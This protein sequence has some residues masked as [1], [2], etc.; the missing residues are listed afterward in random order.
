MSMLGGAGQP[1]GGAP[2]AQMPQQQQQAPLYTKMSGSEAYQ[3]FTDYL[4]K[5]LFGQTPYSMARYAKPE[6]F[7]QNMVDRAQI[8]DNLIAHQFQRRRDQ[9]YDQA[10]VRA[11]N[12]SNSSR[13]V[14][15][16]GSGTS[17]VQL[18]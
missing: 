14:G 10:F 6:N 8:R 12:P 1:Q 18:G 4:R 7:R 13:G 16:G 2:G 15:S 11:I 3:L 9:Y 5:Q 17:T